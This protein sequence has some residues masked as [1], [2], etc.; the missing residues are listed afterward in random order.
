M[1]IIQVISGE[2]LGI[3]TVAMLTDMNN[4][5]GKKIGNALEV[6]ESIKCLRGDGPRDLED[7]VLKLGT[8]LIIKKIYFVVFN[9]QKN[10][11]IN[12]VQTRQ[13][14]F[15]KC[16]INMVYVLYIGITLMSL[17]IQHIF[18]LQTIVS[19]SNGIKMKL[20]S[21]GKRNKNILIYMYMYKLFLRTCFFR[22]EQNN[23]DKIHCEGN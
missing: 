15:H 10:L 1:Y 14:Y 18:N 11:N 6:A 8:Y 4:P 22:V 5:I 21:C 7:L 3:K 16:F 12:L 17:H 2:N 20:E 19:W 9:E 23:V 13:M